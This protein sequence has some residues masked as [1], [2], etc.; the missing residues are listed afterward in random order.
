MSTQRLKNSTFCVFPFIEK[1]QN[2]N[3]KQ[4]LCC[5]SNIPIDDIK[6]EL[7]DDLRKKIWNGEKIEHCTKCYDLELKK[8][9]SPRLVESIKWLKDP[10]VNKYISN[11]TENSEIKIFF[12]DLRI[13]NKCNL[14]CITCNPKDSSLWAK[15]LNVDVSKHKLPFNIDQCLSAKKIYLAGG[16]PLIIDDCIKLLIKI[17]KLDI[18][19]EVV[20]NT[21]LTRIS[22][23]LKEI[24]SKIKNLSLTVSV[25]AYQK[26]NEYHRWP[27]KWSKFFKNLK[28]ARSI[29]CTI[30]FHTVV[31]AISVLN[32]DELQA[33]E[34]YTDQWNLDSLIV[35]TALVVNNLPENLKTQVYEKFC[36]IK[37]SKFYKTDIVFKTKVDN[38]ANQIL[39][40]GDPYLLSNY[41]KHIDER[42][43]LN[44]INYLGISLI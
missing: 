25:D 8:V 34:S 22:D 29:G 30:R 3:G 38:I 10:E 13:D 14:A 31:D 35:P 19:P 1:F 40:P 23:E 32:V 5:N 42:R 17:S 16:E 4:Y 26:V 12:Y 41:I 37:E 24:L 33:I 7:S 11:W 28:W 36:K 21:N 6:S 44:H 2:L 20:I 39:Q 27:L 15:E 43:N 18:Q 9:L